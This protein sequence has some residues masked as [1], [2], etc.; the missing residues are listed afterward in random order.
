MVI[1]GKSFLLSGNAKVGPK[2]SAKFSN[3]FEARP[4]HNCFLLCF[5][6][7]IILKLS[8]NLFQ[9]Y[10]CTQNGRKER[11]DW[12]E[13]IFVFTCFGRNF[14]C[15]NYFYYFEKKYG[16]IFGSQRV[17]TLPAII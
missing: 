17:L 2:I 14:F 3:L 4:P 15:M 7:I 1:G 11:F 8:T 9:I 13:T 6:A 10:L 12:P 5:E 16:S